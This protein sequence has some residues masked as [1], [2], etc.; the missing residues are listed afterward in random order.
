[1][2]CVFLL[3]VSQPLFELFDLPH[4]E[5]HVQIVL[6]FELLE[7]F[8]LCALGAYVFVGFQAQRA[9]TYAAVAS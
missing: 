1:M 6:F 5:Q 2:I 9:Q 4:L 7:W 8:G 3:I